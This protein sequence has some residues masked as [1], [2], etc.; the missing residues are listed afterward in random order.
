M[1]QHPA[2][3]ARTVTAMVSA[4]AFAG[5][6][7]GLA[8]SHAAATDTHRATPSSTPT[9]IPATDPGSTADL[10]SGPAPDDRGWSATPAPSGSLGVPQSSNHGQSGAS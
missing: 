8:V 9:T 4:A 1:S 6:T 10:G 3:R 7:G 2:R 5:L